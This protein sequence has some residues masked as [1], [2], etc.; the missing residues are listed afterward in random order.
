M[1]DENTSQ[2]GATGHRPDTAEDEVNKI[3][4]DKAAI[5]D[6]QEESV[7]DRSP[8]DA[9]TAEDSTGVNADLE[10]PIDPRMPRMPPA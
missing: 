1:V 4:E 9:W 10:E 7:D 3:L 6:A 5:V 2:T 8:E